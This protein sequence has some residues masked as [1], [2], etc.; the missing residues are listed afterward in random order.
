[1]LNLFAIIPS[2][3]RIIYL[4]TIY[5]KISFMEYEIMY[6]VM[7]ATYSRWHSAIFCIS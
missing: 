4:S 7:I 2:L 3:I 5:F 1:M 6:Y